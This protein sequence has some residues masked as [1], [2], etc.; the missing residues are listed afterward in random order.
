MVRDA[1]P[2]KGKTTGA[3]GS[4]LGGQRPSSA[5]AIFPSPVFGARTATGPDWASD[6]TLLLNRHD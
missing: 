5:T 6:D 1:E 3:A 4:G 2:P